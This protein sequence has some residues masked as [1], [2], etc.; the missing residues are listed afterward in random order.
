MRGNIKILSK[1]VCLIAVSIFSFFSLLSSDSGISYNKLNES[2]SL[3]ICNYNMGLYNH[4]VP[5]VSRRRKNYRLRRCS[6]VR[7]F[8]LHLSGPFLSDYQQ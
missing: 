1:V 4:G 5:G 7:C 2:I 8:S 6:A 3:K